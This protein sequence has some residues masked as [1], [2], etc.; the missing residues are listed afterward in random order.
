MPTITIQD[1]GKKIND[2]NELLRLYV[3]EDNALGKK[4]VCYSFVAEDAD[5]IYSAR[6]VNGDKD[7]MDKCIRKLLE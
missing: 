5:N 6:A 3:N 2:L 7:M 1:I 4:K